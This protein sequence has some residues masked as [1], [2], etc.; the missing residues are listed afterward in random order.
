VPIGIASLYSVAEQNKFK[1]GIFDANLDLW[2]QICDANSNLSAMRKFCHSQIDIFLTQSNYERNFRHMPE[3]RQ[4]IDSLE[5]QAKLYL[6]EWG[7]KT[8]EG[9]PLLEGPNGTYWG[10]AKVEPAGLLEEL[11]R[12]P[13]PPPQQSW[14]HAVKT[15]ENVHGGKPNVRQAHRS[16]TLLHLASIAIRLGRKLHWD[17]VREE[18]VNDVEANRLVDPP[19]RGPWHL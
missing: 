14:E 12:F 17:P 15:R 3:A 8:T 7:E 16:A 1:I 5:K 10:G 6:W 18:F 19:M 13:D 4:K 9:K 11:K 2:N